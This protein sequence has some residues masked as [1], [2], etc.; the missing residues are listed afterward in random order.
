[1]AGKIHIITG[2]VQTG[3]SSRLKDW[4]SQRDDIGG[5]LCVDNKGLRHLMEIR[6]RKVHVF[7]LSDVDADIEEVIEVG[8]FKFLSSA[9]D[10]ADEIIKRDAEADC[11]YLVV[12]ELGKLEM[13]DHGLYEAISHVVH[14]CQSGQAG[15][16]LILI[17]RDYLL[18]D[19]IEKFS[20]AS[21]K[22]YGIES[23]VEEHP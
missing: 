13:K 2:A 12:D 19:A 6:N 8:R 3:K 23:F 11:N 18:E 10:L 17:I 7:Q 5:I 20:L 14:M 1:M 15:F 9:F 4:I 16:D 22:I 21:A